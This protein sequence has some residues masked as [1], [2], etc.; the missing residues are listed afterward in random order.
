CS[1]LAA[2]LA[3]APPARALDSFPTRRSSDLACQRL[4]RSDAEGADRHGDSQF[5]VVPR[6]CESHAGRFRIVQAYALCHEQAEEEH[7]HERS[8]EHTSEL[9]S[10]FDLVCR[11]LL[12]KKKTHR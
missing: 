10:R 6:S 7:E 9:Q 8:E 4:T 12:E 2:R 11:L 1:C 3:C 5:E